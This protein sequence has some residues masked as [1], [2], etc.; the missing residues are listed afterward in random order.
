MAKTAY[1]W[2]SHWLQGKM[3][4]RVNPG[5]DWPGM[6]NTTNSLRTYSRVRRYRVTTAG[7]VVAGPCLLA[8]ASCVSG[9]SPKLTIHDGTTSAG[10]MIFGAGGASGIA[11]AVGEA[12]SVCPSGF[13][14]EMPNG[15]YVEPNGT[16]PVFD[17]WVYQ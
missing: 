14:A 10:E 11:F 9:T 16:N 3:A 13:A 7:M 12:K 4:A 1:E 8:G 17:I 5:D 2:L 6:D 15:I